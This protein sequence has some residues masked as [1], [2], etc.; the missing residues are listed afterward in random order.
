MI[1]RLL[2]YLLIAGIYVLS[3]CGKTDSDLEKPG[4][5]DVLSPLITDTFQSG[6][7]LLIK[8]TAIDNLGLSQAKVVVTSAEPTTTFANLDTTG[9]WSATRVID[10]SG[11]KDD[12]NLNIEIP[13]SVFSGRY[14]VKLSVADEY[15]N[16][17]TAEERLFYIQNSID[18]LP[19]SV[20]VNSPTDGQ[21]YPQGA[22]ILFSAHCQ[23][24]LLLA[25]LG[26]QVSKDEAVVFSDL[27]AISESD[28]QWQL[29]LPAATWTS[30]TYT[31][32]L[33]LRDHKNNIHT[34]SLGFV[35][36]N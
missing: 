20:E 25:E 35:I 7:S 5:E 33:I 1:L 3:S 9:L 34:Q 14:Q 6:G 4:I 29:D 10:L 2:P 28:Y 11:T 21:S 13:D 36:I 26:L 19:P 15:G 32:S 23:D 16:E 18:N 24:N 12:I 30:G 8:A 27:L 22:T 31:L 17:Y